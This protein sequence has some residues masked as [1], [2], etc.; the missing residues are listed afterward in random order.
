L[1]DLQSEGVADLIGIRTCAVKRPMEMQE[2]I[3]RAIDGRVKWYHVA[4]IL[5]ISVTCGAFIRLIPQINPKC[6]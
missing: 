5:G 4:E 1:A 6:A 2:V 3:L